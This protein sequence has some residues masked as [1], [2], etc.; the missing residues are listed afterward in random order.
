MEIISGGQSAIP[1]GDKVKNV[2]IFDR[3]IRKT[4]P[5]RV[6]Q[7]FFIYSELM[8]Q[9]QV[10]GLVLFIGIALNFLHF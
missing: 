10:V 8:T 9:S 6:S 2:L 5:S 7:S 1:E 3:L 4:L